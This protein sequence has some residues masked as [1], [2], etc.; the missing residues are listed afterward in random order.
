[1][2]GARLRA[3]FGVGVESRCHVG[4]FRRGLGHGAFAEIQREKAATLGNIF[5]LG[6]LVVT[7][8]LDAPPGTAKKPSFEERAHFVK[9]LTAVAHSPDVR[10]LAPRVVAILQDQTQRET[11]DEGLE[12]PVLFNSSFIYPFIL[13]GFIE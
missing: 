12:F 2:I 6:A 3:R 11:H 5:W 13:L 1:M 9:T 10:R 4:P 8:R 7:S